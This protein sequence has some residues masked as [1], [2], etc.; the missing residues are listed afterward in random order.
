MSI[1]V[2][3]GR[4]WKS[5]AYTA[6]GKVYTAYTAAAATDDPIL[7]WQLCYAILDYC[8]MGIVGH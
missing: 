4:L 6:A 2:A 7:T 3:C 1:F 5:Q 8:R